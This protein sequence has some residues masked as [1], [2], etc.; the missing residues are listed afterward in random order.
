MWPLAHLAWVSCGWRTALGRNHRL[1]QVYGWFMMV[2][3]GN[4]ESWGALTDHL[5]SLS[6]HITFH[7]S[8]VCA[9]GLVCICLNASMSKVLDWSTGVAPRY[10]HVR[11][12]SFL[13][14]CSGSHIKVEKY[15]EPASPKILVPI[16]HPSIFLSCWSVQPTR[17]RQCCD[18]KFYLSK[19]LKT[20]V[21]RPCSLCRGDGSLTCQ[22]KF[23][24]LCTSQNAQP[25]HR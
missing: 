4:F 16:W 5:E 24:V 14:L 15:F 21:P 13:G 20:A 10:V 19:G 3:W 17:T 12:W 23:F 25:Y 7:R 1:S 11:G 22:V 6:C 2:V 18:V 8:K 9:T